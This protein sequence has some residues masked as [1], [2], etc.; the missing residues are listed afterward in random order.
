MKAEQKIYKAFYDVKNIWLYFSELRK[1]TGLS[2]SSLQNVIAKLEKEKKLEVDKKTS[3]VFFRINQKEVP[4]IFAQIDKEKFESL[5]TEVRIPLRNW[6][7]EITAVE[8]IL[9][10]GSASRK[11]EKE[12]SDIDI[13]V[14]LHKFEDKKL[15]DLYE[16]QI[17]QEINDLT[18]KIN[19]ESIYPLKVIFTTGDN[20]KTTKDHLIKQAGETG[21]PIFGNLQYYEQKNRD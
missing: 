9:F 19:S 15:Q 12:D 21:F 10:F 6:L 4:L 11:K 7:K 1:K 8:F 16:K 2:N 18:K 14:V 20:F 17:K 13:L 5:N 3:N